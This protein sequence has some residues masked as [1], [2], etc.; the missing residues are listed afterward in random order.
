MISD[1]VVFTTHDASACKYLAGKN[2]IIGRITIGDDC[3]VGAGSM[4]TKSVLIPGNVIAGNP[5]S[6]VSTI[7]N[8]KIKNE[9]YTLDMR[10]MSYL[11]KSS[12][13]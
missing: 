11:E 3:I 13:Y 2:G 7:D 1:C 9:K 12:I 4:V 10:G 6:V 5:A 8:L